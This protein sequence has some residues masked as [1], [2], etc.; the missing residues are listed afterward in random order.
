MLHDI[1][2]VA[3][4]VIIQ[5]QMPFGLRWRPPIHEV[6]VE[7]LLHEVTDD[8]AARF[9]IEDVRPVDEG[10]HEHDWRWVARRRVSDIVVQLQP[11]LFINDFGGCSPL[12][13][14]L[15]LLP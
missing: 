7:T 12:L 2:K 10:K 3:V 1:E 15:S 11:I 8:A 5:R 13:D 6:S 9:Q 14:S 4:D